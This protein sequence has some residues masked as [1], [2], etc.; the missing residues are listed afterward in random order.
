MPKNTPPN[1]LDQ[2]LTAAKSGGADDAEAVFSE[3]EGIAVHV[4][5]GQRESV[6]RTEKKA[7]GLRVF[8]GKRT[9][10]LSTSDF[11]DKALNNLAEK[12]VSLAK[13]SPENPSAELAGE[14]IFCRD[15]STNLEIFDNAAPGSEILTE[16]ALA[17]ETAGLEEKGITNSEGASAGWKKTRRSHFTTQGFRGRTQSSAHSLF[18]ILLAGEGTKMERDYDFSTARFQEDLEAPE[19]IGK[20]AAERALKRLCPKKVKSA[21]VPVIFHRRVSGSLLGHL[22]GA[23]DG[24]QVAKGITFLAGAMGQQVFSPGANIIDDPQRKRGLASRLFDGEGLKSETLEVVKDG[25]LK[26]WFLDLASASE[27]GLSGNGRASRSL[28]GSPS[29][30]PTNF[31][32]EN[33]HSSLKG[34]MKEAGSGLLVTEMI[35][36]GVNG[37][38][39]DYSRGASGFWFE[40]GEVAYPVSE[41]TIAGNLKEMFKNLVPANDLRFL[42]KI[43]APSLLI[44]KMTVA[45]T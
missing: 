6:E 17:A 8:C 27:L 7:L 36:M 10:S 11:R 21:S 16:R 33:G 4:R 40:N 39:G 2:I 12:A 22:A 26:E 24:K 30:S 19:K 3:T 35:G 38:T 13:K 28:A 18:A 5:L 15:F 14:D 20:K 31:F 37:V 1:I 9:A 29:P 23:L 32:M 44:P 45:G 25:K 34:L 43:N 42:Q 41:I